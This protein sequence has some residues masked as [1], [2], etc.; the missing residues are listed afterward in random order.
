MAQSGR[1]VE[2]KVAL[3]KSVLLFD[4]Q[5]L[6]GAKQNRVLNL[7]IMIPRKVR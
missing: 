2:S 4:G 5:K 3:P 1:G 7:T 6:I